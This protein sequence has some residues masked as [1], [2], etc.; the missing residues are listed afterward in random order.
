MNT[1]T[2]TPDGL[3]VDNGL[4]LVE[5]QRKSTNL[6]DIIWYTMA[7]DDTTPLVVV[8][9]FNE[10]TDEFKMEVWVI[11]RIKQLK[12]RDV[13]LNFVN[14]RIIPPLIIAMEPMEGTLADVCMEE[15]QIEPFIV[16]MAR[17]LH[18]M[19]EHNLFYT[20]MKLENILYKQIDERLVFKFGDLSSVARRGEWAIQTFPFPTDGYDQNNYDNTSMRACE[21]VVGWGVA[22]IWLLLLDR[23]KYCA[24][25]YNNL[26]FEQLNKHTL[27][28]FHT[29]IINHQNQFP[30]TLI[31]M[32][33][34]RK[35]GLSHLIKSN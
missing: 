23:H 18:L 12:R 15:I 11:R 33:F 27:H 1:I 7:S 6:S 35:R 21:D 5:I 13:F 29:Y 2:C 30:A 8:K 17:D 3:F 9:Q 25:V 4:P 26:H 28:T 10:M 32:V 19:C 14:S 24:L 31:D 20:D 22:I 34:L 16:S